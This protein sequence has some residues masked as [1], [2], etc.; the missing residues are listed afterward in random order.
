[1]IVFP[2]DSAL[3]CFR[4]PEPVSAALNTGDCRRAYELYLRQGVK[5][6]EPLKEVPWGVQ[7]VFKDLY[8]NGYA[9]VQAR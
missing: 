9:L 1:M 2:G 5:F 4:K 3:D 8:G 7:A 6:T